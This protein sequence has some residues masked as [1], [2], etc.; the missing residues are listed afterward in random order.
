MI[1]WLLAREV[2]VLRGELEKNAEWDVMVDLFYN[3]KV[4]I[5]AEENKDE[6]VAEGE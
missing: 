3:R 2:K 4:E 6:E 1:Y 5:N